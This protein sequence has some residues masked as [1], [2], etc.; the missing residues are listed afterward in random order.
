RNRRLTPVAKTVP[1]AIDAPGTGDDHD[2]RPAAFSPPPHCPRRA[3]GHAARRL[4][5]TAA[6]GGPS[7]DETAERLPGRAVVRCAGWRM[8]RAS[9]VDRL[10]RSPVER[11][12]RR[13]AG[14]FSNGCDCASAA[15]AGA[16]AY[17]GRERRVVAAGERDRL[18]HR[19]EAELSL[20]D[21]APDDAA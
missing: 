10:R 15:A 9:V 21:A 11:A 18:D 12:H 17:P 1:I 4:R 16:V 14:G 5:A 2:D 13:G 6:A 3:G 7:G 20:P 8:A 19:A